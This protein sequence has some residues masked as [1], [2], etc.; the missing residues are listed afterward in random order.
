M[1]HASRE[2]SFWPTP[3][4]V[5]LVMVCAVGCGRAEADDIFVALDSLACDDESDG[6]W[7]SAPFPG[8]ECRCGAGMCDWLTFGGRDTLEIAHPLGRAPKVVLPY[9]AFDADG[10]RGTLASGD[11]ALILAV[12]DTS[13]TLRNGTDERFYVRLVLE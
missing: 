11:V 8:E 6:R 13:V 3:T 4:L 2:R 12:S 1:R 7:E 10:S 5:A 9:I